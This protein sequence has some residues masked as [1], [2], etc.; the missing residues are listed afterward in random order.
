MKI[1]R[2]TNKRVRH[3]K[4]KPGHTLRRLKNRIQDGLERMCRSLTRD[5]EEYH[6]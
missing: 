4:F 2:T 5:Y 3:N 1:I 6:A